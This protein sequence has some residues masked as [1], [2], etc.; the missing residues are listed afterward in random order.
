MSAR[1]HEAPDC[2][3]R[4]GA[5]T[6]GPWEADDYGLNSSIHIRSP[7]RHW[8]LAVAHAVAGCTNPSRD[9]SELET[10]ANA[11]LIAAAP[12][13]LAAARLLPIEWLRKG[14]LSLAGGDELTIEV[15][16]Q[17]TSYHAEFTIG[18]LR[19]AAAAIALATQVQS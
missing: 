11:R 17:G 19:S 1:Q 18:E 12:D 5:H 8:S 2:A 7:H 4:N 3:G 13:L 16:L 10:R 14:V 6:P 15:S 9:V